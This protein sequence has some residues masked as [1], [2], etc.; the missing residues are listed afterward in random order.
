[1]PENKI[2][3]E[4]IEWL[5]KAVAINAAY[6]LITYEIVNMVEEKNFKPIYIMEDTNLEK[7][8]LKNNDNWRRIK[9]EYQIS[10]IKKD[11]KFKD[12][13]KT[14]YQKIQ[15]L[16]SSFNVNY[17][18]KDFDDI[19]YSKRILVEFTNENLEI[20]FNSYEEFVSQE[21]V[22]KIFY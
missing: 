18:K 21:I 6:M 14:D 5:K 9:K 2:N 19:K 1:M 15:E 10:K 3:K 20:W 4:E 8:R 13:L 17:E 11:Y 22:G 16:Y 7:I 12:L